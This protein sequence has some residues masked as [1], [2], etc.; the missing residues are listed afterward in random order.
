MKIVLAALQDPF[1]NCLVELIQ[2]LERERGIPSSK[3]KHDCIECYLVE[4]DEIRICA[5]FSFQHTRKL[6][7]LRDQFIESFLS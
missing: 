4:Y 3:H 5:K 7:T 6:M 2:F 1:V